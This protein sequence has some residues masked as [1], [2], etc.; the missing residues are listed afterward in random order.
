MGKNRFRHLTAGDEKMANF[1]N[2]KDACLKQKT[3]FN[4]ESGGPS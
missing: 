1:V 4:L 2:T 3:F